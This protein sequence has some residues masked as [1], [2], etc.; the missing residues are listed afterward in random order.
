VND[1][2]DDED[3]VWRNPSE[4]AREL[5]LAAREEATMTEEELDRAVARVQRALAA[6]REEAARERRAR[7]RRVGG[8][9]ATAGVVALAAAYG[10]VSLLTERS[11]VAPPGPPAPL[12]GSVPPPSD[13][14]AKDRRPRLAA[15]SDPSDTAPDAG[16][17]AGTARSPRGPRPVSPPR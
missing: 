8:L 2:Q 12:P 5:I 6:Q 3:V 17:D 16:A 7:R 4:G 14:V 10:A 9:T 13:R 11:P 15:T 1:D